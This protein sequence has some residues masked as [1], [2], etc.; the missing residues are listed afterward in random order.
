MATRCS[1]SEGNAEM[2]LSVPA[3]TDTAT[4]ST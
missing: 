1:F 2:M 4:V 3:D